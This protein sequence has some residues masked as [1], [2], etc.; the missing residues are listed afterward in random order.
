MNL[1][2][3][4][5]LVL[6]AAALALLTVFLNRPES[7]TGQGQLLL[8]ELA[9]KLNDID[10]LVVTAAG[11]KRLATLVKGPERW[12]V[13]DADGYPANVGRIRRNLIELAEARIV[14]TKTAKP[15]FYDRLGVQDV[16]ED[17]AGGIRLDI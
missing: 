5:I 4:T 7:A 11:N 17:S 14:E 3:L 15:E 9:G 13:E 12:I 6:I 8:P 16:S 10:R 2:R 1:R